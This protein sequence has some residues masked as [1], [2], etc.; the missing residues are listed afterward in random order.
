MYADAGPHVKKEGTLGIGVGHEGLAD[1]ENAWE[2]DR[3]F[4][5][6]WDAGARDEALARWREA[7][8]K[9]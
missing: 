4:E 2:E 1:V 5:P 9:A 6:T 7:V 8:A 3:R